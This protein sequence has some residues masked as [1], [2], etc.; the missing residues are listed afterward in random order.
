MVSVPLHHTPNT[1]ARPSSW[2]G[3][4]PHNCQP[5]TCRQAILQPAIAP[6]SSCL[7]TDGIGFGWD[8]VRVGGVW[9]RSKVTSGRDPT[10]VCSRGCFRSP[11]TSNN[12]V[13]IKWLFCVYCTF[14]W[15]PS[16]PRL[17]QTLP[18]PHNTVF[19]TESSLNNKKGDL[20]SFIFPCT[21]SLPSYISPP[22]G[23]LGRPPRVPL[24]P[25][26]QLPR[27]VRMSLCQSSNSAREEH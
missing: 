17:E 4:P 22:V 16:S 7:L 14:F 23:E 18:V 3:G 13:H 2:V 6:G 24:P 5:F 9:Q 20:P 25:P 21:S 26:A 19:H 12:I 15:T 8:R 27:Y 11:Q 1:M 10:T